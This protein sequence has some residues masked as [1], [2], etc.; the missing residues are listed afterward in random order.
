MLIAEYSY[1]EDIRVK[2]QEAEQLGREAGKK[3]GL[4]L[5]ARI[6]QTVQKKP[7][8]TNAQIAMEIGCNT[9]EVESTRKMFGI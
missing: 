9:E 2:Q 8:L 6:F 1:E 7:G 4:I 3:E 5:S